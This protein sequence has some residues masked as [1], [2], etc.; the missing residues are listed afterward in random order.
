MLHLTLVNFIKFQSQ[1]VSNTL[2]SIFLK[3]W[4]LLYEI[5]LSHANYPLIIFIIDLMATYMPLMFPGIC[6]Y[7]NQMKR[8]CYIKIMHYIRI[9]H[10]MF[11]G[12]WKSYHHRPLLDSLLCATDLW[13][14]IQLYIPWIPLS[15]SN[16]SVCSLGQ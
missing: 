5:I 12:A 8:S 10:S 7:K 3:P 13:M 4:I 11:H 9:M 16:S 6:S 15:A 2:N 1:H 14:G